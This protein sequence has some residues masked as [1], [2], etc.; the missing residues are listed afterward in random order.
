M[1]TPPTPTEPCPTCHGY[2]WFDD[3][4]FVIQDQPFLTCEPCADCNLGGYKKLWGGEPGDPGYAP[5]EMGMYGAETNVLVITVGLP[6]SGKTTWSKQFL[7]K[8]PV[9]NV[10]SIRLAL[11][12]QRYQQLAEPFVWATAKT[13]VRALFLAGHKTVILDETGITRARRAEWKSSEWVRA[14]VHIPT[15]EEECIARARA[16][17][18]EFIVPIIMRMAANYEPVT[19]DEVDYEFRG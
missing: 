7:T 19:P 11:H 15:S 4:G 12:G 9:V 5:P 8:Y 10:D 16:L 13:M 6:R 1:T 14:F 18:E 2:R 17:N 3:R